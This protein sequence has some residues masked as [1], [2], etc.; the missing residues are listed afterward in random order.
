MARQEDT[1]W[2]CGAAWV[3]KTTER[4]NRLRVIPGGAAADR[5][6]ITSPPIEELKR[7]RL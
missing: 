3:S 6:A 5:E 2:R 4:P 1:C 7:L